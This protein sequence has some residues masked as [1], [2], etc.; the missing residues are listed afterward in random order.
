MTKQFYLDCEKQNSRVESSNLAF[1]FFFYQV[2]LVLRT[3]FW[4]TRRL[5]LETR[6]NTIVCKSESL[7]PEYWYEGGIHISP[8]QA[9]INCLP[10]QIRTEFE[11]LF[12]FTLMF[13]QLDKKNWKSERNFCL[14]RYIPSG[15]Y[16]CK[17]KLWQNINVPPRK[18]CT[19][20]IWYDENDNGN[21]F[22]DQNNSGI[23]KH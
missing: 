14:E 3:C 17:N 4:Q 23:N 18:K 22:C 10:K 9:S 12:C 13:Q 1:F 8:V 5:D 7:L 16:F 6:E 2:L 20:H 15:I 21:V 11:A 19:A